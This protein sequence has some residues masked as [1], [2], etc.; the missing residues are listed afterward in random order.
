LDAG[1]DVSIT[2]ILRYYRSRQNLTSEVL[3]NSRK[4]L[5]VGHGS[6]VVEDL[7]LARDTGTVHFGG[8]YDPL[9]PHSSSIRHAMFQE[10]F[11]TLSVRS[12]HVA[13]LC[14]DFETTV[15][16]EF[17]PW[18]QTLD[19]LPTPFS[20]QFQACFENGNTRILVRAIPNED[21]ESRVWVIIGSSS[22]QVVVEL[23][24]QARARF[25]IQE[26]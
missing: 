14:G 21:E 15:V 12:P 16:D 20:D 3:E 22:H 5:V 2:A 4:Y 18:L 23:A 11:Q 17:V 24:A 10:V 13:T 26:H 25:A 9:P 19:C 1:G 7:V 6:A 8:L